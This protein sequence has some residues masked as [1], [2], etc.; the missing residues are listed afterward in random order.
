MTSC[1]P[2]VSV[3]FFPCR[4]SILSRELSGP[5]KPN[6]PQRGVCRLNHIVSLGLEPLGD[7]LAS[8]QGNQAR[9]HDTAARFAIDREP[10]HSPGSASCSPAAQS[11]PLSAIDFGA[12]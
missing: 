9:E 10:T 6:P 2:S 1:Q 8:S 11:S 5:P 7:G 4:R 3:R 12:D